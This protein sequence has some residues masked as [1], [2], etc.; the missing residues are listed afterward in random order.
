[1]RVLELFE[2]WLNVQGFHYEC[3]EDG[4]LCFRYCCCQLFC[5]SREEE[6]M[7]LRIIM[8]NIYKVE[9]DRIE[10]L[11]AANIVSAEYS[12][13]KMFLIEDSLYISLDLLIDEST[14]L[15]DYVERYMN[16]II[17]ARHRFAKLIFNK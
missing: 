17:M 8:P 5:C 2:K 15:D 9:N 3:D 16:K 14:C 12:V 13:V 6:P 10:V 1:M 4:N 11:E 7:L